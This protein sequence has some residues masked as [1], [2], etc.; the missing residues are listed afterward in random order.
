MKTMFSKKSVRLAIA[1]CAA[2][3]AVIAWQRNAQAETTGTVHSI[4]LPAM[5][6][7]LPDGPG[8]DTVMAAC[9]ICHSNRYITM[10]PAFSRTVWK[11]E[12]DKMRKTFGAPLNDDQAAQAVDYLVSIRGK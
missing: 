8:R 11:N 4:T 7:A 3:T 2:M 1:G 12:V 10:Q 5:Q 6:P 9:V